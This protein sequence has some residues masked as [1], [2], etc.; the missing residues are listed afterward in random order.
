MIL[1]KDFLPKSSVTTLEH[2]PYSPD[3]AEADFYPFPRVKSALKGR[4]FCDATDVIKNAT[5]ELKKAFTKWLP[6][7]FST[8]LRTLKE[9]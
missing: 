2:P 6:G 9:A 5:E 3:L 4:P 8:T 7:R 1:V